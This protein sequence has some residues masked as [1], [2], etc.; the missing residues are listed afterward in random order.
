MRGLTRAEIREF[1]PN[2]T[3]LAS[4]I[5]QHEVSVAPRYKNAGSYYKLSDPGHGYLVVTPEHA[6]YALAK[7]IASSKKSYSY[8]LSTGVALLEED[9]D[10]TSF[11]QGEVPDYIKEMVSA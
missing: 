3:C 10:A 5:Y 6:A 1:A 11:L 8:M 4:D 9:C 2:R 7:D